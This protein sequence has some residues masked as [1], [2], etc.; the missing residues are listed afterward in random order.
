MQRQLPPNGPSLPIHCD[1][2]R[3]HLY[4]A[5]LTVATSSRPRSNLSSYRST[6][7]GLSADSYGDGARC[8]GPSLYLADTG[9][10]CVFSSLTEE[11]RQGHGTDRPSRS[12]VRAGRAGR[13]D[14]L[15]T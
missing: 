8:T 9:A 1:P 15:G 10:A 2:T 14:R 5:L 13:L 11:W 4:G 12:G 3:T 7:I 6:T